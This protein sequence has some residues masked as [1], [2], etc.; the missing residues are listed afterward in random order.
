MV[1]PYPVVNQLLS[2]VVE[3]AQSNGVMFFKLNFPKSELSTEETP[4]DQ[5]EVIREYFQESNIDAVVSSD[6]VF[7]ENGDYE[8][9]IRFV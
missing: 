4:L 1:S 2:N 5:V 7:S 9:A 3:Y 8:V 6:G